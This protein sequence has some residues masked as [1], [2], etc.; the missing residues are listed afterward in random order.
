MHLATLDRDIFLLVSIFG[1]LFVLF[2]V[3]KYAV[4]A[5]ANDGS[6]VSTAMSKGQY[7]VF[8]VNRQTKADA[9]WSTV[10]DSPANAKAKAE[11]EGLV[12]TRVEW[13]D[14]ED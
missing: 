13:V 3:I 6:A 9:V 14:W 8:G 1:G 2:L 7:R 12:V 4:R 5:G 11:L 10:A